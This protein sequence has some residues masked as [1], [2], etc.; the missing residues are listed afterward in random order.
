MREES[1][2]RSH[3][4]PD[5]AATPVCLPSCSPLSL[6]LCGETGELVAVFP[7]AV[8]CLTETR[9]LLLG[10]LRV[11]RRSWP[12]SP[13]EKRS[14]GHSILSFLLSYLS[15][16]G[17]VLLAT[18]S[19]HFSF[20]HKTLTFKAPDTPNFR[21]TGATILVLQVEGTK[22]R[23]RKHEIIAYF[24]CHLRIL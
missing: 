23:R 20:V 8:S 6:K 21:A 5:Y 9:F 16:F 10:T 17:K 15:R 14:G 2:A 1:P 24:S 11:I 13:K 18:F 19:L 12:A 7:E 3:L 22:N 4:P